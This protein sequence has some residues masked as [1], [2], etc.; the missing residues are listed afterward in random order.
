MYKIDQ[1]TIMFPNG[2]RALFIG[3]VAQTIDFEDAIVVRLG[4]APVVT[5][6]N[7][8]GLDMRG[9]LLWQ[10]PHPRSFAP[11]NPYVSL[12]R[13]GGFVE[14]LNWDGHLVTLHPKLGTI[15]QETVSMDGSSSSRRHPSPRRWM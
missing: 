10:I 7:V 1:K 4:Y 2:V 14:A 8:Y 13:K 5:V 11:E 15:L 3:E 9:K 6:N 12:S